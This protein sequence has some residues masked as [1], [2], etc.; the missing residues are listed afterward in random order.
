MAVVCTIQSG[1]VYLLTLEENKDLKLRTQSEEGKPQSLLL[2][3]R[4]L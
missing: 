3:A 4:E 1:R 2:G